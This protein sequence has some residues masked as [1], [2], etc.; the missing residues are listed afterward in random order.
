MSNLTCPNFQ[1]ISLTFGFDLFLP[2]SLFY[3]MQDLIKICF[4]FALEAFSFIFDSCIPVSLYP[5]TPES[6]YPCIPVSLY[7]CILLSLYP[8]IPVSL[9]LCI[10][11][12]LYPCILVILYPCIRTGT[13]PRAGVRL[14]KEEEDWRILEVWISSRKPSQPES[15]PTVSVLN[16][17]YRYSP[18]LWYRIRKKSRTGLV[19]LQNCTIFCC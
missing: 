16:S 13:D 15:Y 7:H 10:P 19:C 8:C 1:S 5:W 6:L 4:S 2:K 14:E 9:Y 11:I 17:N 18:L 12:S 3:P